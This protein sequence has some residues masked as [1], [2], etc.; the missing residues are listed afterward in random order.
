MQES[1]SLKSI[2]TPTDALQTSDLKKSF[3]SP[4]FK[5][6][7]KNSIY[8]TNLNFLLKK[9]TE[10]SESEKINS[11]IATITINK[12]YTYLIA[13]GSL[14]EIYMSLFIKLKGMSKLRKFQNICLIK[15]K[16]F[17]K[18]DFSEIKYLL[19]LI[20]LQLYKHFKA[21][22]TIEVNNNPFVNFSEDKIDGYKE[23]LNISLQMD[24]DLTEEV[25]LNE[26][27]VVPNLL[28]STIVQKRV[29]VKI[30]RKLEN[31]LDDEYSKP[32]RKEEFEFQFLKILKALNEK[33]INKNEFFEEDFLVKSICKKIF[34]KLVRN[35]TADMELLDNEDN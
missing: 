17:I 1:L 3:L 35:F 21:T 15:K 24:T 14:N 11:E 31:L 12:L 10:I 32:R 34:E 7:I 18:I 4:N 5:E 19:S 30:L 22:D 29:L 20:I 8:E 26:N 23:F 13:S 2:E 25:D 16:D 28:Q 27:D 6:L 9:M 33:R